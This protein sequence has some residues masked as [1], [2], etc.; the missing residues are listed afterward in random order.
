MTEYSLSKNGSDLN[1][2]R[3]Q[4]LEL[5]SLELQNSQKNSFSPTM[6]FCASHLERAAVDALDPIRLWMCVSVA[7]TSE[8]C[9]MLNFI[10]RQYQLPM[11][12]EKKRGNSNKYHFNGFVP[13]FLNFLLDSTF[14][15]H[16]Y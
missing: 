10:L 8:I 4:V 14:F 2:I 1:A 6:T 16:F 13:D 15:S 12:I 3:N 11:T 7:A 5:S 9:K